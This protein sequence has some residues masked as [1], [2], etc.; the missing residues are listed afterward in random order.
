MPQANFNLRQDLL[1]AQAMVNTLNRYVRQKDIYYFIGGNLPQMTVG[2]LLLR[3]R[4]LRLLQDHLS[5]KD[6]SKL[7]DI[8]T[9]H[10]ESLDQWQW[11]YIE[12]IVSELRSRQ[13]AIRY[14]LAEC[15][16][17]PTLCEQVYL[18]EA[19]RR[20]VIEHI[21][22][23]LRRLD[24]DRSDTIHREVAYLDKDMSEVLV[25]NSEFLWSEELSPIY[26]KDTYWWLY[27]VPQPN[28]VT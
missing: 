5:L 22:T 13:L 25:V 6:I 20:T 1:E 11:H 17:S 2:G 24:A 28:N 27:Q 16:D 18:P 19:F 3:L 12:K 4:R 8:E 10:S 14:F 21:L 15:D 23:T 7:L 26:P 9:K